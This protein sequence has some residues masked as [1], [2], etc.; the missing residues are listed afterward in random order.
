MKKSLTILLIIC[1]LTSIAFSDR[2]ETRGRQFFS[3]NSDINSY[4]FAIKRAPDSYIGRYA[5][6][7]LGKTNDAKAIPILIWALRY[8][9][10]DVQSNT[11]QN[12]EGDWRLRYE[13]AKAFSNFTIKK[14]KIALALKRSMD[15][16]PNSRVQ[17]IAAISMGIIGR[18]ASNQLKKQIVLYLKN[19]VSKTPIRKTQLNIA[20]VK[21]FGYN[22]HFS[23]RNFL[24]SMRYRGYGALVKRHIEKALRQLR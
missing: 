14:K 6:R 22:G 23:G 20:L 10:A 24:L 12:Q 9:L 5:I 15:E 21:A 19:K 2:V 4:I 3:S 16:D 11:P 8:G 18:R 17:G 13:A 1:C 7:K